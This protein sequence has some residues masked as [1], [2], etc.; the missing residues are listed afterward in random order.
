MCDQANSLWHKYKGGSFEWIENARE[1]VQSSKYLS[2]PR[3]DSFE[4]K[5]ALCIVMDYYSIGD[6]AKWIEVQLQQQQNTQMSEEFILFIFIQLALGLKYLHG[7]W[8][9]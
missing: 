4:E 6:L 8:E 9:S 1:N 7:M 2:A 3:R 5:G